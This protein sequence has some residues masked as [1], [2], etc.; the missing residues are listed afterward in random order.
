MDSTQMESEDLVASYLAGRLPAG[1]TE[2]FEQHI[3]QHA[4]ARRQVEETLKFK[5]GLAR[6]R[7]Q[8]E[9]DSLLRAP[10]ARRWVPYAAAAAVA[11]LAVS[12]ALWLGV[13]GAGPGLL[14]RSP[15][16]FAT[17]GHPAPAI[18]G[19]YVL[20]RTRGATGSVDATLPSGAGVIELRL[21][22]SRVLPDTR[23]SVTLKRVEV[24]SAH[25]QEAQLDAGPAS[26]D[27]YL[28]V[29]IDRSRLAAGTYEICA[30]PSDHQS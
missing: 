22:P 2:A 26:A 28:A 15:A 29:Y 11:V 25:A 16:E 19:S 27:G 10:P 3:S 5:E 4:P 21:L 30:E 24:H 13:G 8:G 20:A 1:R 17:R 18:L 7:D 6:L 14:A 23:Y 9:L 12:T